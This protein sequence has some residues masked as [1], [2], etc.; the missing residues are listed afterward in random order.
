MSDSEV[1][2]RDAVAGDV[3]AVHRLIGELAEYEKLRDQM[4][5]A[6]SDLQA[7]LF[8]EAPAAGCLV[9]EVNGSIVG[10]ALYFRNY[11]TFVGRQGLY[12]ED[13]FVAREQRGRGIGKRLLAALARKA[14]ELDCRRV[15]WA[16]L[17]WN[18]PA[19]GFYRR[20]GAT[21]MPDWRIVRLEGDAIAELASEA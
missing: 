3:P 17:D 2:I 4:T 18:E 7:A 5:A 20:I 6:E 14:V 19:I 9:A 21:V 8:G 16:V 11:S 13:L 1:E 15:D 12:L 10:F